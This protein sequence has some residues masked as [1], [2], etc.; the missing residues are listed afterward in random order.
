MTSPARILLVSALAAAISPVAC[1]DRVSCDVPKVYPATGSG[2]AV[3]GELAAGALDQKVVVS[4]DRKFLDY[5]FTRNGTTMTARYA[6]SETPHPPSRYFVTIRR[7]PPHGDCAAQ[8][9]R[10][11]VIDA[12]E[13]RRGG[14]VISD[15]RS[16]YA[17]ASCGQVLTNKAPGALNGPP[18]GVGLALAGDA[19]GWAL[20]ER[21]VL[22]S[23]DTVTVTVLD[24]A[25]ESFDV[26]ATGSQTGFD[27]KLG[28]LTGT[29]TVTVP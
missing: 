1:E 19:L 11:P 3:S 10:G 23:G 18:D 7:T 28:T 12:V 29:G 8:A 16:F 6:L 13:V 20:G 17:S 24:D 21:V 5:T 26:Y 25:G 2:M 14:A 22:E 4:P 27:V 9:G 15:A